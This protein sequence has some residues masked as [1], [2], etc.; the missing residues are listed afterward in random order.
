MLF[1]RVLA[2]NGAVD[3][4]HIGHGV[5]HGENAEDGRQLGLHGNRGGNQEA[6]ADYGGQVFAHE[7]Q[8][9]PEQGI[10]ARQQRADHAAGTALG[11]E[12]DRQGDGALERLTESGQALPVGQPVG[13]DGHDHAGK[14]AEEAQRCPKADE[15]KGFLPARQR[16]HH[17]P[18]QH[19]LGQL[20]QTDG[21]ICQHQADGQQ[22]F[23]CEHAKGAQ[24][25]FDEVHGGGLGSI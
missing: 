4:D 18:E 9:Q 17:A 16:I 10:G 14:N 2:A 6:D 13:R 8:P 15:G 19:R 23:G 7:G 3:H 21:D 22:F 12:T 1:Y 5:D 24:V 20:D 25:G 11:V